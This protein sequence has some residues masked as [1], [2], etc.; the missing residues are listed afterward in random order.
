MTHIKNWP[1]AWRVVEHIIN[2][3]ET[4]NQ[5]LYVTPCGTAAC[6][7]GWAVALSG[8]KFATE[9]GEFIEEAI[10]PDRRYQ[11][12]VRT[13]A[14]DLLGIRDS[15]AD[16]GVDSDADEL[17]NGGNSVHDI[18]TKL[19][20]WAEDDGVTVPARVTRVI[21]WMEANDHDE[22]TVQDVSDERFS[23]ALAG[24]PA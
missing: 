7:A 9:H 5:G 21:D 22:L 4:H 13:V 20:K 16:Y 1:L 2:H 15:D 17:F 24:I 18:L 12:D 23:S 14:V 3:P 11:T 6:V 10:S 8:W 19:T